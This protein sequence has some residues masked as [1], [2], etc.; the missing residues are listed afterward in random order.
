MAEGNLESIVI[1]LALYLRDPY[2]Y[3]KWAWQWAYLFLWPPDPAAEMAALWTGPVPPDPTTG[4]YAEIYV[5]Y[6]HPLSR[7]VHFC[8][9][10]ITSGKA[11]YPSW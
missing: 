9:F 4:A 7:C 3:H 6:F 8:H 1:G 5:S 2:T 10:K 11:G